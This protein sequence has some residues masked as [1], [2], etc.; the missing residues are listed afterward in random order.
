MCICIVQYSSLNAQ[1]LALHHGI[2]S[3]FVFLCIL[4]G[5][6]DPLITIHLGKYYFLYYFLISIHIKSLQRR[7]G[8][9][10]ETSREP[11]DPLS[12][13]RTG[14]VRNRDRGKHVDN[15]EQEK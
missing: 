11:A 14:T 10:A 2:D 12:E 6:V 7:I 1:G 15:Q 13:T 5:I 8:T 3:R 4:F 9:D